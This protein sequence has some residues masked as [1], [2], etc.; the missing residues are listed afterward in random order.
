MD[1][2]FDSPIV[3]DKCN[4]EVLYW[5]LK[6]D[7][8]AGR[9]ILTGD[10]FENVFLEGSEGPKV[11]IVLQHPCSM[12]VK[13]TEIRPK[14]LVAELKMGPTWKKQRDWEGNFAKMCLPDLAQ[15]LDTG[16]DWIVHFD[17]LHIVPTAS[18]QDR[19]AI[20]S[21]TGINILLQRWVNY[22]TRVYVPIEK[23]HLPVNSF[24]NETE[25]IETWCSELDAETSEEI[26]EQTS[27][28][29]NWLRE[30]VHGVR[31]QDK[32]KDPAEISKLRKDMNSH[33]KEL[34]KA[35]V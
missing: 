16:E 23:F 2:R 3:G 1:K 28:C 12:R 5:A 31:R 13:G 6:D 30:K 33:I 18:L 10:V 21:P 22:S 11:V 34:R 4:S 20:L 17:D 24:L 15:E 14:L 35:T 9:P 26:A 32:L 8:Y 27:N 19:T 7:I 29:I 25:F